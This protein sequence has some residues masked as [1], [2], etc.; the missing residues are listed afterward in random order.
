MG[1]GCP[2]GAMVA[3]PASA[4]PDGWLL[5]DGAAVSRSTYSG[6][7]A[8]I[9]TTF[10]SGDGSTTFNLPNLLGRVPVGRDAAQTEFD[11]LG[12]T[13]GAKTVSLSASEM[14]SHSH[15]QD[16]HSHGVTDP[17]HTHAQNSHTHIQDP[18]NHTQQAHSHAIPVGATDDTAAPFDRA[19]A[20]A[21]TGGANA[22]T[23]TGTAT[24]VNNAATATCQ[25]ATATNQNASTGVTVNSATATNQSTGGG[26]AHN[27]LQPYLVLNW[28]V[29]T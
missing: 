15:V 14:P 23:A 20:G 27:N 10:G 7:F 3:W 13:G 1:P 2:A 5:C 6:L 4:A 19:D 25:G 28:I 11:A 17:Q 8:V 24:A 22:T 29:K 16:A 26:Q 18:H 21:N 9:G 12:E